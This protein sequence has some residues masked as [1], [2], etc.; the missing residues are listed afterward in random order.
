[1]FKRFPSLTNHYVHKDI[2]YW[3]NKHPEL[4]DEVYIIREKIHGANF[5]LIFDREGKDYKV[6]SRNLLLTEGVGDNF[7]GIFHILRERYADELETLRQYANTISDLEHMR[8]YGEFFGGN[9]QK[10][11]NYGKEKRIRFFAVSLND[12]FISDLEMTCTFEDLGIDYLLAPV[13]GTV[14]G[15][16]KALD[17]DVKKNSTLYDIEEE[18]IMEG[19]VIQPLN[20]VYCNQGSFF[21]LKKKNK[22]FMDKKSQK[23]DPKELKDE[24]GLWGQELVDVRHIFLDYVNE[25]TVQSVFSKYGEIKETKQLGEYIVYVINDA[26]DTF[27]RENDFDERPYDKKQLKYIFNC[28]KVVSDMLKEYL[29]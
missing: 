11:V 18:N 15:I 8:V 2:R 9:I 25:N 27:K 21:V 29:E 22:E 24:V 10:G 1:M 14:K 6:C 26:T 19:G 4:E 20:N 12:R 16:C 3:L 17:F 23:R 7:N 13:L 28:G 5:Q